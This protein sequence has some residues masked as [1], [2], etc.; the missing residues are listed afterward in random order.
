[1]RFSASSPIG[2]RSTAEYR[3]ASPP[4]KQPG[5]IGLPLAAC[6]GVTPYFGTSAP[7]TS[8]SQA[9]GKDTG[10]CHRFTCLSVSFV[11][12]CR[13]HD[14]R[15]AF[16]RQLEDLARHGQRVKEEQMGPSSIVYDDTANA[17]PFDASSRCGRAAP[18]RRRAAYDRRPTRLSR[19]KH[20][21]V[22]FDGSQNAHR[23]LEE[24]LD[25]ARADTRITVVAAA[26]E[27]AP[28]GVVLPAGAEGLEERRRE[29]EDARRRLA[30]LGRQAEVVVVSG[31]P[32][33]VLVE[34]AERRGADLLVVGRRGLTGAERLVMG[35]VSAKVA[36]TARCSVL[37][38][39]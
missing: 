7:G 28:P 37:I 22:G 33:D 35:S 9:A 10:A 19:M 12:R 16:G 14:H 25:V 17:D 36:R 20:I 11:P 34:E 6:S 38:A 15:L 13:E 1:M 3:C 39:R 29:L 8:R 21:L 26:Q 24:A 31:A 2:S 4:S 30:E 23:A 27:P 5:N 18:S 32:A